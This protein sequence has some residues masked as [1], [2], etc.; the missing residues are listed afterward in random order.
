[1][2][3]RAAQ[4]DL[5]KV[6]PPTDLPASARFAFFEHFFRR[7]ASHRNRVGLYVQ[8]ECALSTKPELDR[9]GLAE[10]AILEIDRWAQ[11]LVRHVW[12]ACQEPGGMFVSL[13]GYTLPNAIQTDDCPELTPL[14][15][16]STVGL[17]P[18]PAQTHVNQILQTVLFLHL[19]ATRG[20]HAHTRTFI[21][22]FGPVDEDAVAATLKNPERAVQEAERKSKTEGAR[23]EHAQRDQTLRRVG[24]GLAAVGGG[25]LIGITGGLAAPLVGAGVTTVLGWL[26]VGG[27]AAGLL[28]SGLAGSSVVC[29]ALFGAYGSK[30]SVEMVGRYTREVRDLAIVPVAP[31][32]ETLAVRL[33]VS[34]WLDMPADVAAPWTVFGD[35]DTF[36]LQWVRPSI[37]V[38]PS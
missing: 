30:K 21:T 3:R 19:T 27:T 38:I 15:D 37:L 6:T 11:E 29:G 20:Y 16:T 13:A 7:L 33:C 25:V 34:G 2:A 22:S 26:G 9:T 1:M 23:E 28:A 4:S 36:A 14:S 12:A 10:A 5:T 8:T 24:M 32:R 35:D 18:L 17:P 31:P